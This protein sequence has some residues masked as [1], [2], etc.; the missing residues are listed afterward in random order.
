MTAKEITELLRQ[1]YSPPEWAF[2]SE[3][4]VGTG[5]AGGGQNQVKNPEQRLDGWAINCWP[6]KG[7]TTIAFEIKV[8]RSDFLSE[9]AN[10]DK[11]QQAIALSNEFYFVVPD[12]LVQVEEIPEECGLMVAKESSLRIA[13]RSDINKEPLLNWHFMASIARRSGEVSNETYQKE[14]R[15]SSRILRRLDQVKKENQRLKQARNEWIAK[16]WGLR[17]RNPELW[18]EIQKEVLGDGE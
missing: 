8:S 10:P 12:G 9:I 17:R 2:F 1:R 3:L 11:R 6:S 7:F 14:K 4:R 18:E 5:Y 15:R 13:K 16:E